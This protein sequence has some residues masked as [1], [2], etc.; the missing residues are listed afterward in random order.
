MREMHRCIICVRAQTKYSHL[1]SVC[2]AILHTFSLACHHFISLHFMAD[3]LFHRFFT[4]SLSLLSSCN[5]STNVLSHLMHQ[6]IRPIQS[7]HIAQRDLLV[8]SLAL[9]C[10][11]LILCISIDGLC[12][13]RVNLKSH[14]C[15]FDQLSLQPTHIAYD[16]PQHMCSFKFVCM[17]CT[18]FQFFLFITLKLRIFQS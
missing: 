8:S 2:R 4:R 12:D 6:L 16:F 1:A 14:I 3:L 13:N 7:W 18:P 15:P 10:F 9:L 11:D 17:R 5:S